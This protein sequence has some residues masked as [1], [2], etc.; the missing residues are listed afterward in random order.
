MNTLLAALLPL[1]SLAQSDQ[2]PTL[3]VGDPAPKIQVSEWVK[4]T[5]ISEFRK[6]DVYVIDYWSTWCS[7]CI[8]AMPHMTDLQ[9]RYARDR[10]HVIGLTSLDKYGNSK[11]AVREFVSKHQEKMGYA[12]AIDQT[13]EKAYQGVFQG[14]MA[15]SYLAAAKADFI[16]SVFIIDREGRLAYVGLP[17][18]AEETIKKIV[19]GS[20]DMKAAATK[21]RSECIA[22]PRYNEFL[23]D[24]KGTRYEHAF[25]LAGHLVKTSFADNPHYLWSI[26]DAIVSPDNPSLRPGYDTALAAAIRA[27]QLTHYT[28]PGVLATLGRAHYVRREFADA[29]RACQRAISLAVDGQKEALQKDLAKYRAGV[30]SML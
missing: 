22:L 26:A 14:R 4:G 5:R 11:K 15:W 21:Y 12:V 6:G 27:A 17:D 28:N 25:A 23:S 13:A 19:E 30:K 24:L 18:Q 16:P 2:M 7:P 10:V 3:L 29:A 9:K 20:F 1:F 8:A